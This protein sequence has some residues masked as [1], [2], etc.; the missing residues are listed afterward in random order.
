MMRRM[1]DVDSMII[2]RTPETHLHSGSSAVSA[3]MLN[4]LRF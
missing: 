4:L 3:R 1:I 2:C